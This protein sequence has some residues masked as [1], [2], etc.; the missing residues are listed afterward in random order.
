[1]V[2][3]YGYRA[4]GLSAYDLTWNAP[5]RAGLDGAVERGGWG[6]NGR[7]RLATSWVIGLTLSLALSVSGCASRHLAVS[8]AQAGVSGAVSPSGPATTAP[9]PSSGPSSEPLPRAE[10]QQ[11]TDQDFAAVR[12]LMA[13]RARTVINGNRAAFLSTVD[14]T[15]PAFVAAQKVFFANLQDLPV[16]SMRYEVGTSGLPNAAGIHGGPLLSPPVVEHVY[17]SAT[18]QRPV[19]VQVNNTFVE[20]S[21]RWLLAADS[22]SPDS[23]YLGRATA[24]P[25]AGPRIDV[26]QRG[27]L[28]VVA[29]ASAPGRAAEVAD[30]V[31][32]DLAFDA[33]VLDVPTAD[34]LMVDATSSGSVTTFNND[35]AA[36]AVT[37]AV[38]AGDDFEVTRVAGL[39]VKLNPDLIDQLLSDPVILKH[40]LTHYLMFSY[41]GLNPKWLTEG[42]AEYVSHRPG[43]LA[44]EYLSSES[45]D[46]LM[47]RPRALTVA[48]LFGLDPATDYPLAMAS[49]TYLVNHGGMGRLKRLMAA[50][51]Q[52][53]DGVYGDEYTGRLLRKFY[54]MSASDV[55]RGAFALLGALR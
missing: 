38:G 24:R 7:S 31:Q 20:R 47:S 6:V 2:L 1:M 44:T 52:H 46:R 18:D 35:E 48:G 51:A 19:A 16:T 21:G 49:V 22:P 29:D 54:G 26:V 40:E 9:A 15:S 39:R 43:G 14:P 33:E 45:Y 4:T 25:W 55:A 41:S 5:K 10:S 42:L 11:P 30:Q 8:T 3:A 37:F 13:E 17:F 32:E 27:H 34:H 36:G 23:G 53:T 12:R 50:Y 28:I